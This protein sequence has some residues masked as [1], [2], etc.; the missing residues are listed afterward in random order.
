VLG[1]VATFSPVW[2]AEPAPAPA[3]GMS[4]VNDPLNPANFEKE[5]KDRRSTPKEKRTNTRSSCT[6]VSTPSSPQTSNTPGQ[7]SHFPSLHRGNTFIP[8][9][10][11][12][13][14]NEKVH[15]SEEKEP[16]Y[17]RDGHKGDGGMT[18]AE[19]AARGLQRNAW[20]IDPRRSTFMPV[21]DLI[22][23]HA[24]LFTALVTPVEVIFVDQG[25]AS[26]Q[27]LCA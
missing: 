4:I 11:R 24:M 6:N 1:T 5:E 20:V 12:F 26:F 10:L 9:S 14:G 13:G 15:P 21:W 8:T 3:G 22:M 16:D 19:L 17:Q 18:M 23:V 25:I 7:T 27:P 2:G